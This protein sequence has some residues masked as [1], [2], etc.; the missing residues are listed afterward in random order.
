M[1]LWL[2]KVVAPGGGHGVVEDVEVDLDRV[3]RLVIEGKD[4]RT[5]R[6]WEP[7]LYDAEVGVVVACDPEQRM[8]I[9]PSSPHTIGVRGE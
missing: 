8:V 2:T 5:Y 1:K 4:G 9:L 7:G 3:I 6:V